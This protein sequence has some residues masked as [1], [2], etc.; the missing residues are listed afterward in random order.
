MRDPR[1]LRKL[2]KRPE[3]KYWVGVLFLVILVYFL[4]SD[5]DFSFFLTLSAMV[6]MTSILALSF[7]VKN[8]VEGVSFYTA[9]FFSCIY[10]ARLSSILV[11][12]GYLPFDSSGD[13]FYQLVEI[14]NL[15]A[16]VWV[17]YELRNAQED[18][19]TLYL[20]LAPALLALFGHSTLNNFY[21]TD[22]MWSLSMYLEAVALIPISR[23]LKK[24]I[25]LENFSSHFLAA[26][27][28][29]R[30]LSF[31][32]WIK[33]Y[34]ELNI[35]YSE[36]PLNFLGGYSGYFTLLSELVACYF[37]G[38]FLFYYLKSAVLGTP[39]SLPL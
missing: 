18:P 4:F 2:A 23:M 7:Q 21:L 5:G 6:Q 13:W 14:V 8:S 16:C 30:V 9:L 20:G 1:K 15:T 34:T 10:S 35:V 28:I 25:D 33:S 3:S 26:Q 19:N 27:T 29:A 11:F 17:A 38:D 22:L 37:T 36:Q 32:F 39:M 31:I 12:E 24:S